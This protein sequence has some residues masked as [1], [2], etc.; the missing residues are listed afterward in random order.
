MG[1]C[2]GFCDRSFQPPTQLRGVRIYSHGW[3][4]GCFQ[5]PLGEPAGPS[6]RAAVSDWP[7]GLAARA[8]LLLL[9]LMAAPGYLSRFPCVAPGWFKTGRMPV[10]VLY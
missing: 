3:K 1:F 7:Q 10:S 8:E 9:A 6:E 4:Q 5:P 2:Q